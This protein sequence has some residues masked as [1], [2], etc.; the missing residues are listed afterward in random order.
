MPR[1]LDELISRTDEY[2]ERLMAYEPKES[3]RR[4]PP[5]M[6]LRRAA[7]NRIVAERELPRVRPRGSA[8]PRRDP[9]AHRAA[10]VMVPIAVT[11]R[12]ARMNR[13]DPQ[14]HC[15]SDVVAYLRRV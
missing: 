2:I 8:T 15:D 12:T 3:D 13:K 6:A 7:Y 11:L 10:R 5:N 9:D 1:S 4:E 14:R